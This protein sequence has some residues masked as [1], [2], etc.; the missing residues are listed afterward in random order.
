MHL[1]SIVFRILCTIYY[2]HRFKL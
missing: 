1:E 2:K